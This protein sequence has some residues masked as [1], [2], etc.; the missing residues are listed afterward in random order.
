MQPMSDMTEKR[1][2]PRYS[3]EG[4]GIHAKSIFNMEVE[5]LDLCAGGFLLRSERRL[6]M[7]IEYTFKFEHKENVVSVKGIVTREKLTGS[8]KISEEEIMPIYT[9]NV[10]F[11]RGLT[12]DVQQLRDMIDDKVREFKKRGFGD[13]EFKNSP[14]EKPALP[15]LKTIERSLG[16]VGIKIHEAGNAILSFFETSVVKD[17][18]FGGMRIETERELPLETIFP[19]ELIFA[20]SKN[21]IRCKGRVA[22]CL[23][24]TEKTPQRYRVGVEFIDMSDEDKLILGRYIEI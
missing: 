21:P 14:S 20:E 3:V 15:R 8:K 6:S 1:K 7:G 12:N 19:L 17:I 18:S 4:M 10:K 13:A 22:F 23:K 5:V 9:A 16:R 11:R 24:I 2:Y